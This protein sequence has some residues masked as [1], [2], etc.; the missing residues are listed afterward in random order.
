MSNIYDRFD[1]AATEDSPNVYDRFD[2]DPVENRFAQ[3]DSTPQPE[4]E[5]SWGEAALN[6][7]PDLSLDLASGLTNVASWGPSAAEYL[8][9]DS[10]DKDTFAGSVNRGMGKASDTLAKIAE[11]FQKSK[12]EYSQRKMA[13]P[14]VTENPDSWLGYDFHMPNWEQIKGVSA[15]SVGPGAVIG[16]AGLAV[17]KMPAVVN[18][19]SKMFPKVGQQLATAFGFSLANSGYI[20][21]TAYSDARREAYEYYKQQGLNETDAKAK[22]I[23]AAETVANIMLPTSAVTGFAGGYAAEPSGAPISRM[24]RGGMIEA[25]PEGTEEF[26]Q[27]A[28]TDVAVDRPVDTAKALSQFGLGGI[29]GFTQGAMFAGMSD[30]KKATDVDDPAQ[31]LIDMATKEV[32]HE[33]NPYFTKHADPETE[34]VY[35]QFDSGK[36]PSE[37][38]GEIAEESKVG[39]FDATGLPNVNL[40]TLEGEAAEAY[41]WKESKADSGLESTIDNMLGRV[42]QAE[43]SGK[44]NA[45][46]KTSSASGILQF[47]DGTFKDM[48]DRH[49][50]GSGYS[51]QDKNNPEAQR[52]F[53]KKML[54]ER[55]EYLEGKLGRKVTE[56][57]LYAAHVFG[58]GGA[59]VLL[60]NLGKKSAVSVF[61]EDVINANKPLFYTKTGRERSTR[62]LYNLLKKKVTTKQSAAI[63]KAVKNVAEPTEAQKEAGNYKKGHINI[64]GM[65]IAIEN[66]SGSIRRGKDAGGDEWEVEMPAHYGYIKRTKGADGE[67]VDVYVGDNP[68]SDNVF[69]VDQ[70]DADTKEFDEHK[71]MLGF[72]TKEDAMAAYTA[73]FD[74]GRGAERI[75]GMSG[76]MTTDVFR[77]WLDAADTS[78]PATTEAT[79]RLKAIK[80]FKEQEKQVSGEVKVEDTVS[81]DI[82]FNKELDV[83]RE[84]AKEMGYT[85][86]PSSIIE[87]TKNDRGF[88]SITDARKFIKEVTGIEA[89]PNTLEAK[90]IDEQI[91]VG[92][93]KRAREIAQN[94]NNVTDTFDDL[95]KLYDQQPNLN[96]RTSTS[97]ENQAYSTP[98]PIS[99]LASR[100]AD[101][102]KQTTVYDPAAGHGML[103][104]E[105]A[106]ENIFA[107]ELD[108]T[109][110]ERMVDILGE[111]NIANE[112]AVDFDLGVKVDRVIANPPF[113]KVKDADGKTNI[114]FDANGLRT[115][116]IDQAIVMKSLETLK[117]DGK[118]AFIIGGKKGAE[119]TRRSKYNST[120]DRAFWKR[121][122]NNHNV[123]DHFS[124]DG[125][126]YRKQG[127]EFPLDVIVIDGVGKSTL[128]LPGIKPPRQYDSFE[129][130][131]ELLNVEETDAGMEPGKQ[132]AGNRGADDVSG[133][134]R[135]LRTMGDAVPEAATK[136]DDGVGEPKAGDQGSS[137]LDRGEQ[138]VHG[139]DRQISS[140]PSQDAV[141]EQRELK[142]GSAE[143]SGASE[144]SVKD[145]PKPE[146]NGQPEGSDS[147]RSDA[148]SKPAGKAERV[149][150]PE[151]VYKDAINKIKPKSERDQSSKAEGARPKTK[152]KKSKEKETDYQVAYEPTSKANPVGTLVPVNMRDSLQKAINGLQ[153]EHG[154]IDSYV[155][156]RLNYKNADEARKYFSAEQMEAIAMAVDNLE[157]GAGFVIGDQTG[158]GKGRFVAGI[159]RYAKMTGRVPVF[160]TKD[161]S[162]YADMY[163]DTT[164]IGMPKF[165]A[166]VTNNDLRG[167]NVISVGKRKIQSLPKSKLDAAIDSIGRTG[168]MPDGYDAIFTTYSQM[169]TIRGKTPARVKAM[170][171]LMNNAILVL[172]ESH[173]AGG[174][175]MFMTM[176]DPDTGEEIRNR[177]SIIR[178]LVDASAGTVYSSA[179]FAKNPDVM[180]LYRKT[181]MNKS[182]DK[183]SDLAGAI[184]M[185]GVP[186]QQIVSNMLVERGQYRRAER[187]Y[188][189]VSMKLNTVKSDLAMADEATTLLRKV[190]EFDLKMR[191]ILDAIDEELKA[192]AEVMA[193]DTSRG[194]A[195]INSSNFTSVMH[196][197]VGQMLLSLKA[198]STADQAISAYK[199]GRKPVIALKNTQGAMLDDFAKANGLEVG[200]SLN[201]F[202]FGQVYLR[203]LRKTREYTVAGDKKNGQK[204]E[205]KFVSDNMLGRLAGE[206]SALEAEIKKHDFSN[207]PISPID[208]MLQTMR[209]AGMNAEEIT[210]RNLI[211]DYS[212]NKAGKLAKR[213]ATDSEKRRIIDGF[214]GGDIDALILNQSGSTGISLH[215]SEKFNDQKQRHMI[216]AQPHDNIDVF[217]QMLGRIHRTG[218]VEL[219]MYD[220]LVSDLPAE[221]RLAANLMRKMASLNANTTANRDS[222]ISLDNVVDFINK[223]GDRVVA[224]LLM[225]DPELAA[226]LDM[227]SNYETELDM[228][229]LANRMT[230]R[231]SILPIREQEELYA[232]LEKSYTE[233]I[234]RLERMGENALEAKTLDID[235]RQLSQTTLR[236]E[237]EPD[238]PFTEAAILG[239][240]DVKRLGKPHTSEEVETILSDELKGQ[241]PEEY[242]QD[243]AQK[244]KNPARERLTAIEEEI[245]EVKEQTESL[246]KSA[247]DEKKVGKAVDK[248]S[249]KRQRLE[250]DAGR[251]R[252][253]MRDVGALLRGSTIG[254]TVSIFDTETNESYQGIVI[255][256]EYKNVK[257]GLFLGKARLKVAVADAVREL[258]IPYS[259]LVDRGR[260]QARYNV[261][262]G[263]GKQTI[264]NRMDSGQSVSREERYIIT[265]NIFAGYAKLPKGQITFFIDGEGKRRAGVLMSRSFKAEKELAA[266]P[267]QV[268]T[269]EQAVE[270]LRSVN[271]QSR[272]AQLVSIDGGAQIVSTGRGEVFIQTNTKGGK[273]YYL[274]KAAREAFG[275]FVGKRGS[276][277]M[278]RQLSSLEDVKKAIKIYEEELGAKFE[279]K[280][281]QSILREIKSGKSEPKKAETKYSIQP[282]NEWVRSRNKIAQRVLEVAKKINP[283]VKVKVVDELLGSGERLLASGAR[284]AQQQQVSG[285][286]SAAKNLITV[287]LNNG[288]PEGTAFHEAWHSIEGLLSDGERKI[289]DK[290]FPGNETYTHDEQAAYAFQEWALKRD[291]GE[292]PSAL[293]RIF[294]K[295]RKFMAGFANALRGY[296]FVT[297]DTVFQ[298]VA[299][300]AVGKRSYL[301]AAI[302]NGNSSSVERKAADAADDTKYSINPDNIHERH[303][304]QFDVIN[305]IT[306]SRELPKGMLENIKAFPERVRDV[307]DEVKAYGALAI[308]VGVLDQFA[309][310]ETQEKASYGALRDAS[311]SAYKAARMS[312]GNAKLFQ[313]A[314][315]IRTTDGFIGG[316]IRYNK[317]KGATEI[318]P[319]TKPFLAIFEP[320]AEQ[321]PEMLRLWEGW[322][323]ANRSKR[324]MKEGRENLLKQSD[325]D[326]LLKL[327]Q[328]YPIFRQ[329]MKDWTE[330]NKNFLDMAQNSGLIDP[331]SRKL[332]ESNDYV[333]FYR[334]MEGDLDVTGPRG[335][336]GLQGQRSGIK[337]LKG[338]EEKIGSVIENMMKNVSH[339]MD[340][341]VKNIAMQKIDELY[342]DT[343][344]WEKAPPEFDSAFV[345]AQ[346]AAKK[347]QAMG[348]EVEGMTPDQKEEWFNLFRMRQP[349]GKDIV[350]F[351]RNGKAEYRRVYDPLLLT[352]V[353]NLGGE[354]IG[355]L[356]HWLGAP[357]RWLTTG[358]TATP[359][360]MTRNSIRDTL[361]TMIMYDVDSK[362][363]RRAADAFKKSLREDPNKIKLMATGAGF[364]GYYQAQPANF[365]RE[366][367]HLG[368]GRTLLDTPK[369]LWSAWQKVGEASEQMN[370]IALYNYLIQ[371]GVS[372]AEAAYQARDVLDFQMQGSWAP[373]QFFIQ[374]VPFLNP[375]IQ[376]LYKLFRAYQDSPAKKRKA[377]A[378]KVMKSMTLRGGMLMAATMALWALN[379]DDDRYQ[380][381]Q[382]WDKDMYYH[383]WIGD[384]HFTIPKPFEIGALFSTIPER[385]LNLISGH[386]DERVYAKAMSRMM[387]DTFSF[388]PTP[389][390]IKPIVE[391]IANKQFF[392]GYPIVPPGMDRSM[393]ET[394]YNSY[395]SATNIAIAEA[396][397]SWAPEWLRSPARVEALFRGYFGQLPEFVFAGTDIAA[398]QLLD[399]PPPPET[400]IDGWP[401]ISALYRDDATKSTKWVTEYYDLKEKVDAVHNSVRDYR[402]TGRIDKAKTL[403]DENRTLLATRR[404][405]NS[406][407]QKMRVINDK[408][409]KV[410]NSRMMSPKEKRNRIDDLKQKR[411][412]LTKKTQVLLEKIDNSGDAVR[413][414][415]SPVP[416]SKI[417]E[418]YP[419]LVPLMQ[420]VAPPK[421][422]MLGIYQREAEE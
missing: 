133:A 26:V 162:L 92:F 385:T 288:N 376:G 226:R 204:A 140:E 117:D 388:D 329:V 289:L 239:R 349:E 98:A 410:Q 134:D 375:R 87:A 324:L 263:A 136:S 143:K 168:T 358:V 321:G 216:I 200:D 9:S 31:Q 300:G 5:R 34:N 54:K 254:N 183:M 101:I 45:K 12:S 11:S 279:A 163:R 142:T 291:N 93:T 62:E 309:A 68:D 207:L 258:S 174:Q 215:A 127:A 150:S 396:M 185:G 219:P 227:R 19:A 282:T 261:R 46:S 132:P 304:E 181:D 61:G 70:I 274:N 121:L 328:E 238:N 28:G 297:A 359:N 333:P 111:T 114:L 83:D 116:E 90:D 78:K 41:P 8:T 199:E 211:V 39:T 323:I 255:G 281:D 124:I 129:S 286:Y 115:N 156:D 273:P 51:M 271:Q 311:V 364:Y 42:E 209:D 29:G 379:E 179:T 283:S 99:F 24:I 137:K 363:V 10:A 420:K 193:G 206:Y 256:H 353:T 4:D 192:D 371:Q 21:P 128:P 357:K 6:F 280:Q 340:A 345:S 232:T 350:S 408:M 406:M 107:N 391:Q 246:L 341:S 103:L 241:K 260:W 154:D 144:V 44:V 40:P 160:L 268:D 319:G 18:A 84:V 106:P 60:S 384:A 252:D 368:K 306:K 126:L 35:D 412:A 397:P 64:S 294:T 394:Q 2:A 15:Q 57:D 214:N 67:H 278:K 71:V 176:K 47:T 374:V 13:E 108:S 400:R 313:L 22:S 361:S 65:D 417:R 330:F 105:A 165:N 293:K 248:L 118:A 320:I 243:H 175:K 113:G 125:K 188:D 202:D 91:E 14:I 334:I 366:L 403:R 180:D 322:A 221:K 298:D 171:A 236:D 335:K 102:N 373:V 201:K 56:A 398:R 404:K 301:D 302:E 233:E 380:D 16:K 367:D 346:E 326:S 265:G 337:R 395:T 89:K 85:D 55:G 347:L 1:S 187:S 383:I 164:D 155:A 276:G 228:D 220:I 75:G 272:L 284:T 53:A 245:S 303:E 316:Q 411:N 73:A 382:E 198:R 77:Q 96:V 392:T 196:N 356:A 153:A 66:P 218:Q 178:D 173:E 413:E 3:P 414:D 86:I 194:E 381:L 203:Y 139:R 169:Q 389:Q 339:L 266:L 7:G 195:G 378:G 225:D 416:I 146:P 119:E 402:E 97:K 343:A 240:F 186:L 418:Q 231:M 131:K 74:D 287:A 295:V 251:I 177:A 352:A 25:I 348:V 94:A 242:M 386:D 292:S 159:M 217:M 184:Q 365:A 123:I 172:D 17:G 182:V 109:R 130:L 50:E 161:K 63:D 315:G 138:R 222:A 275:D 82:D 52:Y 290:A 95:V 327:E 372:E 399:M 307:Y 197:L 149:E 210:G 20:T 314:M 415:T 189:G 393:P 332:W 259:K 285:S 299:S 59:E 58:G 49:G 354:R 407:Y 191:P 167:K 36:D 387:L 362:H 250:A 148:G 277:S 267:E 32:S 166:F 122:Y 342:Q 355:W 23:E 212:G 223:Y 104:M 79:D 249:K 325:I 317:E 76:A 224:D 344:A 43:S 80:A 262:H 112:N 100:L 158:V 369:D 234:E 269:A 312:R 422:R 253:E 237:V 421:G 30:G 305:R 38:L 308:K 110:A 318:I 69:I 37:T 190:Y 235:A 229:G 409:Q 370:R 351:M 208:T 377:L 401:I 419:D 147:R 48:L 33:G 331:K 157:S 264:F 336:A 338:G 141:G 390:F 244:I 205:R 257:P 72:D 247:E 145:K 88:K 135:E 230:G 170:E 151:K 405:V 120:S 81:G 310:L 152:K 360:F 270:F 296:G 27:S 213:E